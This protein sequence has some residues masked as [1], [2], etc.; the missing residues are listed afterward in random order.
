MNLY[1]SLLERMNG[2]QYSNYFAVCCPFHDDHNPSM[3]VYEDGAFCRACNHTWSL[4][5]VDRKIGSHFRPSRND[6]V[7][8]ILPQ[9]KTWEK[10]YG[11]LQ[12]I[13][14]S[15]HKTL[16]QF[17]QFQSYYKKRKCEKFIDQGVLGFIMGWATIPVLDRDGRII[18][19][20]VRA[21]KGKGDT[22]YVVKPDEKRV[23]P[24]YCPNWKRVESS[25]TVYV[26]YGIFDAISLELLNL[27]VVTGITGK[28]LSAELLSTL[29]KRF[30]IVPD[31][32]EERDA[33]RLANQLGWRGRVKELSYPDE[34]KDPS[35]VREQYGNEYLLNLIGVK[36]GMA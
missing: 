22:R 14:E 29:R 28:S 23:R 2:R 18:D 27:P 13:A 24:L 6:T 19:I 36:H 10:K 4:V 21:T 17:T 25:D 8:N 32:G 20:V 30:I 33:H 35:G 1:D 11:D 31:L 5:Q 7:S 3:F 12:G 26:V 15:A 34:I 16:K 9:W